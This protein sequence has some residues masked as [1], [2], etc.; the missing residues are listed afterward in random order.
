MNFFPKKVTWSWKYL[1]LWSPGLQKNF[2]KICKTLRPNSYIRMVNS[3]IWFWVTNLIYFLL[4][5]SDQRSVSQVFGV[6]KL[7]YIYICIYIYIYIY[8]YI[9]RYSDTCVPGVFLWI[10]IIFLRTPFL[11]NTTE[12]ASASQTPP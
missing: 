2:W 5:F 7:H 1:A 10:F 4:G 8:I 3:F 12:T 11:Q 9:K 6:L